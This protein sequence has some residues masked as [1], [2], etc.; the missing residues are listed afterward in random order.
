M[1]KL[2]L[3]FCVQVLMINA[4]QMNLFNRKTETLFSFDIFI[5]IETKILIVNINC[6][7]QAIW[8]MLE[9]I[10]SILLSSL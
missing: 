10:I 9:A 8:I 4:C 5:S 6:K 1:G 2:R 7:R 3:S